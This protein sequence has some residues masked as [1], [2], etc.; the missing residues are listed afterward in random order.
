MIIRLSASG[1]LQ[2]LSERWRRRRFPHVAVWSTLMP[3]CS[4]RPGVQRCESTWIPSWRERYKHLSHSGLGW[5]IMTAVRKIAFK[6]IPDIHGPLK[7]NPTDFS[8]PLVSPLVLQ[9]AQCFLW[10]SEICKH[11]LDLLAQNSV[12]T[13]TS[14]SPEDKSY[15]LLLWHQQQVVAFAYPVKFLNIYSMH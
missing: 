7:K 13:C 6:Y 2:K 14:W 9:T 12:H 8:D 1:K 11:L 5:N 10:F 4:D 3:L 15:W